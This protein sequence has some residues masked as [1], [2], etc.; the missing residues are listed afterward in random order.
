MEA[1]R[2]ALYVQSEWLKVLSTRTER[3]RDMFLQK[4]NL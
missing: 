2:D 3:F 1:F 4:M